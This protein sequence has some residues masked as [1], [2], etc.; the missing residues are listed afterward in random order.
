VGTEF[1]EVFEELPDIDVMIL[2]IGAGSEAAAAIT[3][4]RSVKK[5][6]AI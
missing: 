5:G 1:I 4:L 6:I 3:T 2:P